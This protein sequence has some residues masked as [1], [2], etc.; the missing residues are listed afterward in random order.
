MNKGKDVDL[1]WM[2]SLLF[3]VTHLMSATHIQSNKELQYIF[4]GKKCKK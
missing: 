4:E 1:L 2:F 3:P